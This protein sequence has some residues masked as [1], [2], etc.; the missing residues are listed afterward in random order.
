VL[1][2]WL[3]FA[4]L[5]ALGSASATDIADGTKRP[6]TVLDSIAWTYVLPFS[7][8]GDR[9]RRVA[10]YSPDRA[11]FIVHT[12]R[13]DLARNVNV[14]SLLLFNAA[15]VRGYVASRL[16]TDAA[17]APAVLVSVDVSRDEEALTNIEWLDNSRVGFLAK[18]AD[19][20]MQAFS[21]DI[22]S[23]VRA[24]LSHSDTYTVAFGLAGES[25]AYYA[26]IPRQKETPS[27]VLVDSFDKTLPPLEPNESGCYVT[28]PVE[29]FSAALGHSARRLPLLAVRLFPDLKRIW[30]SPSGE[31]AVIV[32][33]AVNAP[34]HWGEYEG[35]DANLRF[36]ADW[37]RDDATSMDLL[38]RT[39]YLLVN[40][41][42]NT[43][44]PLLDAPT[45]QMSLNYTPLQAFWSKDS[46]TVIVTNTFL[47][48]DGGNRTDG[49]LLRTRPVIA[50]VD[51][52][53]GAITRIHLDE[54]RADM[55]TPVPNRIVDFEWDGDAARLTIAYERAS[56]G[57][58]SRETY[59]KVG[60][61]WRRGTEGSASMRVNVQI[62]EEQGLN[63]RP[64]IYVR[65]TKSGIQKVLFDPNPQADQFSFGE[66]RAIEW[67]DANGLKW[68]GG[69]LLPPAYVSGTR[70]PLV[71]QTHGFSPSQ[72]LL[73]GP[74]DQRGGVTAFAAQVLA[75]AGFVVLQVEDNART[76]TEDQLEGPATAEGFHAAIEKLIA[77]GLVDRTSVGLIAF[78]RT[79]LHAIHLAAHYPTMLAALTMS[80]TLQVGYSI[81]S[82]NAA[83]P[84]MA[85]VL[86]RLTGGA[87][88][89]ENIGEW[90]VNNP[91]YSLG[92]A[93]T[94][95][96]LEAMV[97]G[98]GM[99]E[100]YAVLREA[101]RPVEFVL[102][103][104]GSHVLQKPQ[105]RLSSQGGNVD[106]LR[107]WLQRYEDPALEKR[108]QY[109]RWRKLRALAAQ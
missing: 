64:R 60:K 99:W 61:R 9:A 35:P 50:E 75:N 6:F 46:R 42:D 36:G 109:A 7:S 44:K 20:R 55:Q 97:Q 96:R 62:A 27:V 98:L 52:A 47:P 73:D 108:E 45:G 37:V 56:D 40:L 38:N 32:A 67:Q 58:V 90:F 22:H 26:C 102:Y 104:D 92:R 84:P 78:S 76:I 10:L 5:T 68:R 95:V 57:G 15:E 39:R 71:V 88:Q 18:A 93:K 94:A 28:T 8:E 30:L 80:D 29:F 4:A 101:A 25:L 89:L 82:F 72:F 24:Q 53:S 14:S 86:D 34:S 12:R 66:T 81:R 79:G 33:P 17:P 87:P 63:E 51:I 107:F 31:F 69:L 43:V 19:G 103:P 13:G 100:T 85:A 21:A 91:L 54:A 83:N 74:G 49:A 105:E 48:L 11:H 65:E 3:V 2:A 70:Y 77:D 41:R 16:P 106:W 23:G 59:V 1:V